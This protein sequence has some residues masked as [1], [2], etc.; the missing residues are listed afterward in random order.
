[1]TDVSISPSTPS[2]FTEFIGKVN[3]PQGHSTDPD[4][5]TNSTVL[6]KVKGINNL[7]YIQSSSNI[8]HLASHSPPDRLNPMLGGHHAHD[9]E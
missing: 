4:N 1:M 6:L 7:S 3:S 5:I 9:S 2:T 8:P